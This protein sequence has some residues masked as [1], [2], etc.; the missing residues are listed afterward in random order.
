[1][2]LHYELVCPEIDN[3]AAN[4]AAVHF[5]GK[6]TLHEVPYEANRISSENESINRSMCDM[7]I[8]DRLQHCK[9]PALQKATFSKATYTP[10]PLHLKQTFKEKEINAVLG[11]I[12][13]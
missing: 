4:A 3:V 13:L 5:I 7:L 12:L 8:Q 2:Q 11:P 6:P 1:M 9:H 10:C